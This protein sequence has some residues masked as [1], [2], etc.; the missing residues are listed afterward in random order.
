[1]KRRSS[2]VLD[3][4]AKYYYSDTFLSSLYFPDKYHVNI[5]PLR[6]LC[7]SFS[8]LC[9]WTLADGYSCRDAVILKLSAYLEYFAIFLL[10]KWVFYSFSTGMSSSHSFTGFKPISLFAQVL[11]LLAFWKEETVRQTKALGN[12]HPYGKNQRMRKILLSDGHARESAICRC[13]GSQL[14][15]L[16]GA[17]LSEELPALGEETLLLLLREGGFGRGWRHA[18][19]LFL[20]WGRLGVRFWPSRQVW[21]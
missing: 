21:V 11:R 4:S 19:G 5:S 2:A 3:S 7:R 12:L 17:Q 14:F 16:T 15:L 6:A 9:L 20:I 8:G 13:S 18:P 1:M 10:F